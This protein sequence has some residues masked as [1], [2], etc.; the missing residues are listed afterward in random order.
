MTTGL[1]ERVAPAESNDDVT[2]ALGQIFMGK[3]EE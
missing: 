3:F 2:T 1:G